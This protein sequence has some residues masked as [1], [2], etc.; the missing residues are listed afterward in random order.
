M[1]VVRMLILVPVVVVF[2]WCA[3]VWCETGKTKDSAGPLTL[4][5]RQARAEAVRSV[6]VKFM[7]AVR[8]GN[9]AAVGQLAVQNPPNWRRQASLSSISMRR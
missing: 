8:E 5:E 1:K 9:G 7:T 3:G 2:S 4:R 6:A